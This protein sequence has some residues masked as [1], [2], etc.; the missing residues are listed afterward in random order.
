[1]VDAGLRRSRID[2]T[3]TNAV[4]LIKYKSEKVEILHDIRA[5]TCTRLSVIDYKVWSYQQLL[6][7]A[8][9][10]SCYYCLPAVKGMRLWENEKDARQRFHRYN[11]FWQ[12]QRYLLRNH[13]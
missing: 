13:V 8:R 9:N 11:S 7:D 3:F 4:R 12:N 1:M 2:M 6:S 10:A 5:S